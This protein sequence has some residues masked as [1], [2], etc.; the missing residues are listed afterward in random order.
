MGLGWWALRKPLAAGLPG[1]YA[2][3]LDAGSLLIGA[4]GLTG[5]VLITL[6]PRN[7]IG[8]IIL[9]AG[10]FGSA[11]NGVQAFA[12]VAVQAR[13]PAA[14]WVAWLS[15]PLWL[16]AVGLV[17]GPLFAVYPDGRL[18]AARWRWPVR[19]FVAGL[20]LFCIGY[21]GGQ[22]TYDDIA[23]GPSPLVLPAWLAAAFVVAGATLTVGCLLVIW[24]ATAVRLVRARPPERQQLAWL[25]AVIVPFVLTLFLPWDEVGLGVVARYDDVWVAALPVAIGVGVFRYNLLGIEIVLRRGLVYGVLTAAVLLVYLG[26]TVVAGSTLEHGPVPAVVA[27][28]LVAVGLSPLRSRLQTGVDRFVYGERRDPMRAVTRLAADVATAAD[29][30]LLPAMLASVADALRSPGAQVVS[31]DG[32]LLGSVGALTP[33][34]GQGRVGAELP[35]VVA[36]GTV[37]TLRLAARHPSDRFSAADHALLHALA[38]Q[39]A[40]AVRALELAESLEAA[41]DRLLEVTHEERMRLRRELH[42]GLGPA[43]SGLALGLGAASDALRSGQP[44]AAESLVERM[45]PEVARAVVEVRRLIDGLRPAALDEA[46]DLLGALRLAARGWSGLTVTVHVDGVLPALGSDLETCVYRVVTEALTNVARHAG[47]AAAQ[48][49]LR[50][51]DERTLVVEVSD[52]GHGMDVDVPGRP[53]VGLGS[54]RRRAGDLGGHLDVQSRSGGTTVRLVLPVR[55]PDAPARTNADR[56]GH[57]RADVAQ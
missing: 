46:G 38:P 29:T 57:A 32:R 34:G 20:V 15:S 36:G 10:L 51:P 43:L 52:D 13:W 7:L 39:V 41:R 1:R 21:A 45:E 26:V 54:M 22:Q 19:L 12:G 33:D 42:D 53:G 6:R 11:S 31:A 4:Y 35:L 2:L 27:A 23:P 5:A 16:P 17:A 55:G 25:F 9:A 56:A 8:W 14:T 3:H 49:R 30:A 40:V 48:I 44:A 37:G 24:G 18:A 50:C 28:G 47:A